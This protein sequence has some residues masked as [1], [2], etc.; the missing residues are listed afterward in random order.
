MV[1]VFGLLGRHGVAA[2]CR[3]YGCGVGFQMIFDT[4]SMN[5][6]AFSPFAGICFSHTQLHQRVDVKVSQSGFRGL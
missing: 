1:L 2:L 6:Y 5:A 4:I 3:R